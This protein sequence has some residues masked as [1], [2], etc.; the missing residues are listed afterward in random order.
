MSYYLAKLKCASKTLYIGCLIVDGLS[1]RKR[2]QNYKDI[3]TF[4]EFEIVE[5]F[6]PLSNELFDFARRLIGER[7]FIEIDRSCS[8]NTVQDSSRSKTE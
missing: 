6:T 7:T 1:S 2:V 3:R 4:R 5:E 8:E